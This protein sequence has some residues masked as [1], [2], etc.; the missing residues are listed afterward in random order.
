MCVSPLKSNS[1]FSNIVPVP[2]EV[3]AFPTAWSPVLSRV[4]Q[5]TVCLNSSVE[6]SGDLCAR[7]VLQQ[8]SGAPDSE[9][10]LAFPELLITSSAILVEA[11]SE[12]SS[13]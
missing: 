7:E 4:A 2:F 6:Y 12:V 11:I 9:S 5:G 3:N 10:R 1:Y 13:A 8:M